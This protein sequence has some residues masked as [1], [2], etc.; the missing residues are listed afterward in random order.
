MIWSVDQCSSHFSN[1]CGSFR[2]GKSKIKC[3]FLELIFIVL[4]LKMM[5]IEF[6]K[7][8]K[9]ISAKTRIFSKDHF[10]VIFE[11]IRTYSPFW[12]ISSVQLK[13]DRKSYLMKFK[14]IRNFDEFLKRF[15]SSIQSTVSLNN[16]GNIWSNWIRILIVKDQWGESQIK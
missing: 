3:K 7:I 1:K 6:C 12:F 2:K 11:E 14:K 9:I 13:S 4:K 10:E 15:L 8:A 5:T 16:P